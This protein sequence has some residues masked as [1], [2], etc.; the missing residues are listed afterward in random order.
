MWIASVGR[1]AELTYDAHLYFADRSLRLARVH[2]RGGRVAR[3]VV[4]EH[5]ARAHLI[6]SGDDGPP[7]AAAMAMPRPSRFIRT[8]A[9]GHASTQGPDDAA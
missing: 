7:F 6:L 3:A 4:L 9:V 1:D 8:D 2:R 5:K